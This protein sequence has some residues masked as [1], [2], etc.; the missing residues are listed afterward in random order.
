MIGLEQFW[1]QN[2]SKEVGM[3]SSYT[4]TDK[5]K[6]TFHTL[7]DRIKNDIKMN[8]LRCG[9]YFQDFDSLRK[10]LIPKIKFRGVLSKMNL[11][12]TEEEIL[13]L[14]NHYISPIDPSKIDYKS[15]LGDV[16]V[17]FTLPNLDKDPL[18]KPVEWTSKTYIDPN[19]I[20]NPEEEQRLD[21][22]LNKMAFAVIT[23]RLLLKP[24]FQDK[25][26][27]R[28]GKVSFTR[29]RSILDVLK[30]PL[31]E[32]DYKLLCKRFGYMSTEF[33]YIEFDEVLRSYVE[34][35]QQS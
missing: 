12:V 6:L 34:Q 25:D 27:A 2:S 7:L 35:P 30:L 23:H 16:E 9:E 10:G 8:R 5:A 1:A 18:T 28:C 15:F 32:P 21:A 24:F 29:F 4:K 22:L 3:S 26:K 31:G 13:Q 14:E 33:N 17:V 20:L 11:N 19:N